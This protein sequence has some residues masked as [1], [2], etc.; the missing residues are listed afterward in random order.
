MPSHTLAMNQSNPVKWQDSHNHCFPF[1][2]SK[3]VSYYMIPSLFKHKDSSE[4]THSHFLYIQEE[5]H[6]SAPQTE[7]HLTSQKIYRNR[8]NHVYYNQN[9]I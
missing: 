6:D 4:N 3:S 8:P 2:N 5:I 9:E 7:K 1:P